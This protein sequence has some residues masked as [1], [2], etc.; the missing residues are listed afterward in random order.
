[1]NIGAHLALGDHQSSYGYGECKAAGT[2]TAR[3]HIQNVTS[4]LAQRTVGVAVDN[5][6]KTRGVGVQVQGREVVHEGH[7]DAAELQDLLPGQ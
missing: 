2:G 5:R 6:L 3:V 7:E 1:M 4:P